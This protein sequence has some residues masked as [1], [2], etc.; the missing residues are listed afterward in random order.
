MKACAS[1]QRI[2]L[3]EKSVPKV[4]RRKKTWH[5]FTSDDEKFFAGMWEALET[6]KKIYVIYEP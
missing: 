1:F 5:H 3:P 4:S 6:T 2:S